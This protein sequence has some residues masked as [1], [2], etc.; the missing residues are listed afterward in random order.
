MIAHDAWTMLAMLVMHSLDY[1]G[2][3][4][5]DYLTSEEF[6]LQ[7]DFVDQGIADAC[8]QFVNPFAEF[9]FP[10]FEPRTPPCCRQILQP[11]LS[12]RMPTSWHVAGS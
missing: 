5:W 8:V 3:E 1:W 6:C 9:G 4:V 11:Y 7:A 2:H 10:I 12:W